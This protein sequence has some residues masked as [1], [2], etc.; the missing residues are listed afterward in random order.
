MLFNGVRLLGR[1]G[2]PLGACSDLLPPHGDVAVGSEGEISH[3]QGGEELQKGRL[4][5][6]EEGQ[7]AGSA[8][9]LHRACG[10][11]SFPWLGVLHPLGWQGEVDGGYCQ[12]SWEEGVQ[13]H[14]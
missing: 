14:C 1:R 6:E 9:P 2:E 10:S 7:F 11:H 8:L 12:C 4:W 5:V 3:T 13:S